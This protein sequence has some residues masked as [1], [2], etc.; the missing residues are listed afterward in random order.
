M[1]IELFSSG[2]CLSR[3][4]EIMRFFHD[5]EMVKQFGSGMNRILR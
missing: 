2:V 3:N 5:V 4:S 1:T